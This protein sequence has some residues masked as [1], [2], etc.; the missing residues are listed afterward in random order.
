MTRE[1]RC[2]CRSRVSPQ[3]RPQFGGQPFAFVPCECK[4]TTHAPRQ[5]R[6][7]G[8]ISPA[9]TRSLAISMGSLPQMG[10]FGVTVILLASTVLRLVP[11][12]V[13]AVP[14]RA[15]TVRQSPEAFL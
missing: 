8:H 4:A 3:R 1:K 2:F 5:I 7:R 11:D 14:P 15:S 13:H 9:G 6:Q 12:V 10:Q